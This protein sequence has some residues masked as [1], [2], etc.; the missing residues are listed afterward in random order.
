MVDANALISG[1]RLENL[2]D[3][4]C[5]I[6]EVLAEVRDKQART[7]LSTLPFSLD[8]REPEEES[9]KA[10][11][12]TGRSRRPKPLP[13]TRC[14]AACFPAFPAT[15]RALPAWRQRPTD[16][17]LTLHRSATVRA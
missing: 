2:A 6:P 3:R 1:L 11:A 9:L 17:P 8:V 12:S 14:L 4:F 7:F 15:P 10:G 5:T 13:C 16:A